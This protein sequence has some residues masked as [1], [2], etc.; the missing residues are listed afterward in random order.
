[1][2]TVTASQ[3]VQA[4]IADVFARATNFADAANVIK[5]IQEIEI[6]T[7]G[8][9]GPGTSFRETRVMFGKEA[10]EDMTVERFEPPHLFTL[11]AASHGSEY[12]STYKLQERDGGTDLEL[13]FQA[14]PTSV[15][16]K[17]M[18]FCLGKSLEKLA[19]KEFAK[20]LND[21]RAAI[22]HGG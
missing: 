5:G 11:S 21:L 16:A 19:A 20:D 7:D 10:T 13:S 15:F 1:M 17:V 6:L 9:V 14:T 2:S 22:E 3:H 12:L 4:P 8:P 18:T